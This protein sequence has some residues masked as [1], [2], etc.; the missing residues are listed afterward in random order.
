MVKTWYTGVDTTH[1]DEVGPMGPNGEEIPTSLVYENVMP[2]ARFS[3]KECTLDV[4]INGLD[5][6]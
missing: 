4:L 5:Q 3:Q 6:V 2:A 1:L